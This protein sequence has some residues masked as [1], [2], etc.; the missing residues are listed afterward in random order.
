MRSLSIDRVLTLRMEP[1]PNNIFDDGASIPAQ[2]CSS[3][4]NP[5]C[6]GSDADSAV[7]LTSFSITPYTSTSAVPEPTS[8]GLLGIMVL[9]A[10]AMI[11]RKF[12]VS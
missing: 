9:G 10:A 1:T 3:A 5:T 6:V 11:R 2:E 4:V 12:R 8:L 7:S